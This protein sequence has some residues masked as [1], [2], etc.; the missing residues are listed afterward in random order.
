[1]K[2]LLIL[3]SILL[4]TGILVGCGGSGES[5]YNNRSLR[6]GDYFRYN[7]FNFEVTTTTDTFYY[8]G[9]GIKG[10]F[11]DR[12]A[13][14]GSY[15]YSAVWFERNIENNRDDGS[16]WMIEEYDNNGDNYVV[17][18]IPS[19]NLEIGDTWYYDNRRVVVS[20]ID[21]F[22]DNSNKRYAIYVIRGVDSELYYEYSPTMGFLTYYDDEALKTFDTRTATK[23]S[24]KE[25]KS[26]NIIKIKK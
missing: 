25:T 18:I 22:S 10:R 1:M 4:I 13:N 12:Y 9:V 16:R 24:I 17:C 23:S 14:G 7:T 5:I 26:N 20:D 21:F 8:E 19:D 6:A 2:K 3:I 11:I 15:L